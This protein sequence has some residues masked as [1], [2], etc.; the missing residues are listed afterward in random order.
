MPSEDAIY[1]IKVSGVYDYAQT[2]S[3]PKQTEPYPPLTEAIKNQSIFTLNNVS[4]TAVGF[5][6]PSSMDGVDF[7][8]YHLHLITDDRTAG[9]HLLDCIIRNATVEIDQIN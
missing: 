4:A 2:R 6:F 5:W 9:G 3:V 1:V 8:G 7:A